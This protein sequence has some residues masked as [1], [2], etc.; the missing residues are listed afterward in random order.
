MLFLRPANPYLIAVI[1]LKR[2]RHPTEKTVPTR[3]TDVY[4]NIHP[5]AYTG[6]LGYFRTWSVF[7]AAG[8]TAHLSTY[9]V[10]GKSRTNPVLNC[11]KS[12]VAGEPATVWPLVD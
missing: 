4:T 11:Q 7:E 1:G 8:A 6:T 9:P 12:M 10:R 3:L 5:Q 2:Y